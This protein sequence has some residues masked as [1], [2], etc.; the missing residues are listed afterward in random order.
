[1]IKIPTGHRGM[2]CGYEKIGKSMRLRVPEELKY[3]L[4][5]AYSFWRD[6]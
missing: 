6:E 2:P 5:G 4:L 3:L 1:M